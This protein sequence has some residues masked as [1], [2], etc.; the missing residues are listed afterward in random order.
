MLFA[1]G[2]DKQLTKI[3]KYPD[4]YHELWNEI[5]R[6]DIFQTMKVWVDKQLKGSP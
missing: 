4:H 3:I 6:Q 5:D 2:I 1:H